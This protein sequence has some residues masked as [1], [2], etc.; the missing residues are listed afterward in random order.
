MTLGDPPPTSKSFEAASWG[1]FE[2]LLRG[3]RW[4][5]V[6]F[7]IH[8]TGRD[9]GVTQL[10]GGRKLIETAFSLLSRP[11][12]RTGGGGAHNKKKKRE[13]ASTLPKTAADNDDD[14]KP[15]LAWRSLESF[16]DEEEESS[17]SSSRSN[18]PMNSIEIDFDPPGGAGT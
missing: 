11:R 10:Q 4:H 2:R 1:P 12:R 6:S 17:S 5:T 18:P 16:G 13:A 15:P 3:T 7:L 14:L 8:R 9:W